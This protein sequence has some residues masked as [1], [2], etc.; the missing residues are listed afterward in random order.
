MNKL[1]TALATAFAAGCAT[2]AKSFQDTF[3]KDLSVIDTSPPIEPTHLEPEKPAA[4]VKEKP[5]KA[6]D[7]AKSLARLKAAFDARC[8]EGTLAS[9]AAQNVLR[10]YGALT[11]EELALPHHAEAID[12]LC[13][14]AGTV[15]EAPVGVTE[16]DIKVAAGALVA[17]GSDYGAKL[18]AV[19]TKYGITK[20]SDLKPEHYEA[21]LADLQAALAEEDPNS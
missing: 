7:S 21:A 15:K 17:K 3:G 19:W 14:L 12:K 1:T 8:N 20:R 2:F 13:K 6:A 16:E 5:A 11:P 9:V 10:E 4:P 18:K